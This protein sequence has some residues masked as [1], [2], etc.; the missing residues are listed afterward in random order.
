VELLLK[1]GARVD[2]RDVKGRTALHF[3]ASGGF[4]NIVA[5]LLSHGAPINAMNSNKETALHYAAYHRKRDCLVFLLSQG[6]D[7]NIVSNS[8]SALSLARCKGFQDIE[9]LL[10]QFG[11]IV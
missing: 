7:V 10:L 4:P 2:T 11:A 1:Y 3:S 5:L 8:G 6:A 9:E